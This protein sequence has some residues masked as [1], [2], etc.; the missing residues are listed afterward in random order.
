MFQV[1]ISDLSRRVKSWK[2]EEVQRKLKDYY[3]PYIQV[4]TFSHLT[5]I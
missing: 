4:Q 5:L 3:F 1:E 2:V